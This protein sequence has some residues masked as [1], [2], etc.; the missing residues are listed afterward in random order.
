[1]LPEG[2]IKNSAHLLSLPETKNFIETNST[3]NNHLPAIL[4]FKPSAKI[5]KICE[6]NAWLCLGNTAKLNRFLE[7]KIKF[8][9]FCTTEKLPVIPSNIDT[10]TQEN[11]VKY[12]KNKPIVIQSHFGWAGNSTFQSDNFNDLKDKINEDYHN[13]VSQSNGDLRNDLFT[14]FQEHKESLLRWGI[15]TIV[16]VIIF[17]L[18]Y[19]FVVL[20]TLNKSVVNK[21]DK[22]L[23]PIKKEFEI[24]QENYKEI[25]KRINENEKK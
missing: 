5:D 25:E 10:F 22:A 9:K 11:F 21:I 16:V 7:D 20:N 23:N 1:Y 14:K 3:R 2:E 18:P 4:S 24:L 8:Y 19:H 13:K 17:L 6:K 12:S 15:G